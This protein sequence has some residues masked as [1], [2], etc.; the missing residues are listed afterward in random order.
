MRVCHEHHDILA[1]A[2]SWL[3]SE[4]HA[5]L[6]DWVAAFATLSASAVAL[7]VATVGNMREE[8]RRRQNDSIL[9][10]I[11][12]RSLL[13]E[14]RTGYNIMSGR[15][16]SINANHERTMQESGENYDVMNNSGDSISSLT[17]PVSGAPSAQIQRQMEP[18]ATAEEN[19][20]QLLPS[21]SWEGAGTIPNN[22]LLRIIATDSGC[23]ADEFSARDIRVHCKN[24]FSHICSNVNARLEMWSANY[25]PSTAEEKLREF[26]AS[27]GVYYINDTRKVIAM[28]E[29]AR[30][31][32]EN[33][34]ARTFPK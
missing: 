10:A 18:S 32:L 1:A 22:V 11:I 5:T 14:V 21:A 30:D 9:G 7:W 19:P 28:L 12:I 16:R 4:N 2:L 20:L 23:V 25:A 6:A 3:S 17:N 24:Y 15:P 8:W 31:R 29:V 27:N 34:A 26:L 33:N 13:E